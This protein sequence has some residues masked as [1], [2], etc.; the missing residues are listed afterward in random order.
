MVGGEE[1]WG[2]GR[3]KEGKWGR[4]RRKMGVWQRWGTDVVCFL[5]NCDGNS[6]DLAPTY[7]S[8]SMGHPG[9]EE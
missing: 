2:G 3:W 7:F 9:G 4:V 8:R 1:G 6:T 5:T